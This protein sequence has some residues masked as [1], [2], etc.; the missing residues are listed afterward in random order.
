MKKLEIVHMET[1]AVIIIQIGSLLLVLIKTNRSKGLLFV[2]IWTIMRVLIKI[3]RKI[4][5]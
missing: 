5:N 2:Q 1:K 3:N 4:S